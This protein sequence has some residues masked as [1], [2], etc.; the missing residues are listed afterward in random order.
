MNW[1][2]HLLLSG[3]HPASRIGGLLP[4]L[5]RPAELKSL[6]S[7]FQHGI[8]LH[9][10]ID[11]FTDSHEIFRA[12]SRRLK[13][14]LRRYGGVLVDLFYDHFLTQDWT[15]WADTRLD[16]FVAD[17][18]S[19]FEIYQSA[20]PASAWMRMDQMRKENWLCSYRDMDGLSLALDRMSRRFRRPVDLSLG[21][22]ALELEY[23]HFQQDFR[24]FFP[25]LVNFVRASS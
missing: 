18:Y 17:F 9:H 7:E 4:D 10:Q 24:N 23:E 13:P 14:N 25:E 20:L 21:L 15:A 2:A 19:S 8:Q 3:P 12:S 11:A 16:D 5:A 6:S 22:S 1:L